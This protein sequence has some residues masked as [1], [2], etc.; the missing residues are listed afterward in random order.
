[1][2]TDI[3]LLQPVLGWPLRQV[4]TWLDGLA[5][6]EPVE[7]E[8]FN[9]ELLAFT[10]AARAHEERSLPWARLALMVYEALAERASDR[11]RHSFML[12]AMNLRASMIREFGSREGDDVLDSEIITAWFQR[13]ATLS[14]E[15]AA[16]ASSEDLST[17]PLELLRKLRDIK[18]A[19][20]VVALVAE[21]GALQKHPELES[22]LQLRLGLP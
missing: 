15:E 16:R 12:S 6:G 18:N 19:L 8:Y 21:T 7:D 10:A 14:I 5:V 2:S 11:E 20:N 9:W 3:T 22:W 17:L 4:T 1:M 13:I